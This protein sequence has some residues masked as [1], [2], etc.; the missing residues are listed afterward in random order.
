SPAGGRI[1]LYVGRLEKAKGVLDL[2]AAFDRIAAAHPGIT[3]VLVG[4]GGVRAAC[5]QA[6]SRHPGRI[7]VA[8]ARPLPEVPMWMSAA[9]VVC[10]PS[11]NEGTPNVILE[12]LA[13]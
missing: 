9:D 7:V 3:L 10:L 5:E 11:W 12:A 8:G 2:L 1:V 4:D 6:A 13:C